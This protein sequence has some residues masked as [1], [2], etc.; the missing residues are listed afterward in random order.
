MISIIICTRNRSVSLGRTLESIRVLTSPPDTT[1]ELVVVDNNSSDDTRAVVERF[2]EGFGQ[3]VKYVFEERRGL[4]CARNAGLRRARGEIIAFTDDDMVVEREWLVHIAQQCAAHPSVAMY[5]G[6]T[7]VMHPNQPRLAIREGDLPI[8]YR[9][10][11][12]PNEP[13]SGNNMILRRA[14]LSSV[15]EFDPALGAGTRLGS[16]EDTDFTYR[17]LR[18]GGIVRYCPEIF[19]LHD[20]DRLSPSAVR[21]LLFVYGRGRGGFFCKH[22]VRFDLWVTK[23]FYWE[24]RCFLRLLFH[25]SDTS[26]ALLHLAG[27]TTGFLM[28]LGMEIEARMHDSGSAKR[29]PRILAVDKASITEQD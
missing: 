4:S 20:H 18:S 1:W 21:S 2:A 13:G 12:A 25:R 19:A 17:V 23:L 22:I 9:S 3:S 24:A 26:R 8:T 16:S 15:V 5:F 10:P 29:N 11:C 7:S 6:Q 28:R 14:V 27:L